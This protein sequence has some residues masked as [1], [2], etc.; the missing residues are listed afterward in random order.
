MALSNQRL[1]GQLAAR[2]CQSVDPGA[3]TVGSAIFDNGP[4]CNERVPAK[5]RVRT[6][7]LR[8]VVD[9]NGRF[10]GLHG[11][12]N[13]RV[14]HQLHVRPSH[15]MASDRETF[16]LLLKFAHQR[17]HTPPARLSFEAGDAPLIG[18]FLDQLET[19]RPE[20]AGPELTRARR[21]NGFVPTLQV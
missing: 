20:C 18:A 17:L 7:L 2:Q 3:P 21:L 9:Q 13:L 15:T 12:R 6:P 16:R 5:N 14:G 11:S 4:A 19:P 1:A 8:P 10:S